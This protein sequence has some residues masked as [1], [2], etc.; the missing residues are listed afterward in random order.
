MAIGQHLKGSFPSCQTPALRYWSLYYLPA[1]DLIEV[2]MYYV[3]TDA[4]LENTI[5]VKEKAH[6][7]CPEMA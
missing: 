3:E 6:E 1:Y 4:G 7:Q 2:Y 5:G